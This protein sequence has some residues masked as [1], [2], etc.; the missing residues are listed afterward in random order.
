MPYE[1]LLAAA[2][3]VIAFIVLVCLSGWIATR[4]IHAVMLLFSIVLLDASRIP[5]SFELGISFYPKDVVF[6][7]LANA[8]IVRF[9]MFSSVTFIPASWWVLGA[10]QLG[11]A[12][13]GILSFGPGAGVDAREHFY[14]WIT[15]VYFCSIKWTEG[16]ITQVI[17]MWIGCA[18]CL[19]LLAYYHWIRS[20]LDPSYEQ[21]IMSLDTT[22]V[23]FRVLSAGSTMVIAIGA[24][25]LF[26]RILQGRVALPIRLFLPAM[27]ITIVTLQHRSVWVSAFLG[28]CCLL[29]IRPAPVGVA[30]TMAVS[31]LMAIPLLLMLAAPTQD[32]NVVMS[33]KGSADRAMSLTEG[34][35]AGRLANWQELLN[36]WADSRDPVTYAIGKPYGSGFNPFEN[37]DGTMND[38]VPH[39]HFIHV[40]Y[41]GGIIG[42]LATLA[43][44]W[45]VWVGALR[46]AK[47]SEK[48]SAVFILSFM[49]ALLAYC[50]PYW[51]AYESG[52]LIGIALSYFRNEKK[53]N[54]SISSRPTVAQFAPC[55]LPEP[56]AFRL[57]DP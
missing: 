6:I 34:T 13:W 22:G 29:W 36:K 55:R 7:L 1:L 38:M 46:H 37:W 21:K 27:L 45:H 42:L 20:G 52:I 47:G 44:F 8:C 15:V 51:T 50:I 31:A 26:F 35:M 16:M 18:V 28:L 56:Y 33:I 54:L 12:V 17:N 3:T 5:L 4:P 41:R 24:L 32:N 11:L 40:L 2:L 43:V 23:R 30:R 48:P 53:W 57:L 19:S 10:V 39:N 14:L 25:G 49:F 9:L